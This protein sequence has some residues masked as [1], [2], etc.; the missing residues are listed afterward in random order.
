MAEQFD[1]DAAIA[2]T[3]G[4]EKWQVGKLVLDWTKAV[5]IVGL[6]GENGETRNLSW[7]G[8][9]ATDLIVALNKTNFSSNSLQK[10]VLEQLAADEKIGSG[11]TTGT[12]T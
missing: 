8:D 3:G 7:E 4:T 2:S 12:P 1:L 6:V 5:L 11:S 10:T 9:A